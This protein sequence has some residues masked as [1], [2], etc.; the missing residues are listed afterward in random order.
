[1]AFKGKEIRVILEEEV[2]GVYKKLNEIV[3]DEIF[4]SLI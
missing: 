2:N 4:G 1:M 3:G